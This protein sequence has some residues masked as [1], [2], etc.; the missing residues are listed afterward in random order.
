VT[1]LIAV[2]GA[3][4]AL[5]GR[6]ARRLATRGIA[7]RLVVRDPG[8]APDLSGAEV[9]SAPSYGDGGAMRAALTGAS[10]VLLVSASESA[11]RVA[12]HLTAVDAA[13]EAGVERIVYVSF[14]GAAPDATFTLARHHFQTEERIRSHGVPFTFLRDSLYLDVL[15]YFVGADGAIRGPAGE[16]RL[17]PVARDDIADV[18]VAVLLDDAH[19]GQTYDLTGPTAVTMHEVAAELSRASGRT[20]TYQ[21]ETLAEAYASRAHYGA[22]DWEVEG[23]VTSYAAVAAGELDE[24]TDAV[25]RLAGHSPLGIAEWLAANPDAA[26][27]LQA[28]VDAV[29]IAES[30][31]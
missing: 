21:P 11:D 7:Q 28:T 20:I 23:W 5:G 24:V 15:P 1:Y 8:R 18:A 3:T 2:T 9:V 17:A 25:A 31:T 16:G 12:Q 13:V 26:A 4:G 27:H 22:P 19:A 6:V 10:V 29:P 30:A 14:L